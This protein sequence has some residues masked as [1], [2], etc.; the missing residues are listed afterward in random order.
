L[1]VEALAGNLVPADL[2]FAFLAAIDGEAL[3]EA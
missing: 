3:T 1:D 2:L